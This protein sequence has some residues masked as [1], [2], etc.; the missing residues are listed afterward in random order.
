VAVTLKLPPTYPLGSAPVHDMELV[1]VGTAQTTTQKTADIQGTNFKGITVVLDMTAAG[2]GSVFL[3]IEG[4]DTASGKYFP[5]LAGDATHAI[6][7]NGTFVYTVYPGITAVVPPLT[8]SA[9]S[10]SASGILPATFRIAVTAV[11]ANPTTYTVGAVLT[12]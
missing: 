6:A 4:K 7:V 2:T 11:N 3:T 10:A 5:I 1:L 8:A 12:T 9:G